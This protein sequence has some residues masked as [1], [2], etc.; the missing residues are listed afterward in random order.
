M[1]YVFKSFFVFWIISA[2]ISL[3]LLAALGYVAFHFI[4]KFWLIIQPLCLTF[5]THYGKIVGNERE[6]YDYHRSQERCES[7]T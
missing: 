5:H 2:L 4:Q 6:N 1:S 3:I 7:P